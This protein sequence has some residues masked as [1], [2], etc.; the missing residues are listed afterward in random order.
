MQVAISNIEAALAEFDEKIHNFCF[1]D[2]YKIQDIKYQHMAWF[3]EIKFVPRPPYCAHGVVHGHSVE[4]A[5]I[6][7]HTILA[8]LSWK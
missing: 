3:H 4:I 1:F 8:K 7:S 5:G 2:L 6:L